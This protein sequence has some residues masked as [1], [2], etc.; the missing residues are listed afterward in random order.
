MYLTYFAFDFA[1]LL[2][3]KPKDVP[4]SKGSPLRQDTLDAAF[5]HTPA[6][7]STTTF[8]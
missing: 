8:S 5:V 1:V 6:P 3:D 4:V 2:V 7:V